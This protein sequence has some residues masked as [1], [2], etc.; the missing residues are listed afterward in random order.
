MFTPNAVIDTVQNAKKQIVETF[1]TDKEIK[2]G[3][4]EIINAQTEF[5]KTATQNTIDIS[6]LFV[7]NFSKVDYT[8]Y[9]SKQ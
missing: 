4:V 5:V 6:K 9:F 7:E 8:K 2:K 1:V 3:L